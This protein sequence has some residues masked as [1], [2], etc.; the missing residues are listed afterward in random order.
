MSNIID[1]KKTSSIPNQDYDV[2]IV[3]LGAAGTILADELANKGLKIIAI[4]SG[5]S[6]IEGATQNLYKMDQK[7]VPYYDMTSCRLRYLGGTTNHWGGYC[8]ANDPIDYLG[9][10]DLNIPSWPFDHEHLLPYIV[11]ASKILGLS[12]DEYDPYFQVRKKNFDE[13][14]LIEKNSDLLVTKVA[15]IT[16]KPRLFKEEII[17]RLKKK[18]NV[19]LCINANAVKLQLSLNGEEVTSL[20]IKSLNGNICD[21]KAK[22]YILATHAVENSR[23]LLASDDIEKKGIGNKYGHVGK[24]FME[25]PHIHSGKMIPT[26]KFSNFY[27]AHKLRKIQ[28]NANLAF[29]EKALKENGIL[30]YYCRF[31]PVYSK[32]EITKSMQK[33]RSSFWE[34]ADK[35]SLD[36]LGHVISDIPDSFRF[37]KTY[38]DMARPLYYNLEHRIE[39]SPNS[40]SR[41]TLSDELDALG[42]RKAVLDWKLN[43]LDIKTFQRGQEIVAE[44][45]GRLGMGSFELPKI[46]RGRMDKEVC[47]HYHHMGTTRMSNDPTE[48]VVDANSKVHG[49]D[50]LF[51]AGSSVFPTAGYSGPTMMLIAMAIKLSEHVIEKN[52]DVYN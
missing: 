16:K 31:N 39:Q 8:H 30:Q 38:F 22:K 36:A 52:N 6:N 43:D 24:Y 11:K 7:G 20:T 37:S 40:T 15:Q 9:R 28:L 27:D 47:G 5:A 26:D 44:E 34:P 51:I 14:V 10:D 42:M 50:N 2:C 33:L 29:S 21:I 49:V 19:T 3:G 12:M 23:L 41:I 1:I 13:S 46:T 32:R 18:A 48:G 17:E 25:H 35:E 45:L 4:E